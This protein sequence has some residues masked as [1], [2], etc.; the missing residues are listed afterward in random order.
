[1]LTSTW[2]GGMRIDNSTKLD[3]KWRRVW[4][5]TTRR[6]TDSDLR[7]VDLRGA[8]LLNARLQGANLYRADLREAGLWET[9]LRGANLAGADLT[10]AYMR[11]ADVASMGEL[12][13]NAPRLPTHSTTL[14]TK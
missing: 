10:G 8:I 11:G 2:M 14:A 12:S 6:G 9:D 3:P 4:A 7:G 5:L 13:P 1:V